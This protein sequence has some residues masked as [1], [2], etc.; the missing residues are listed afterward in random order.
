MEAVNYKLG[1]DKLW[2]G[3]TSITFLG[4]LLTGGKIFP[5]PEKT[6]AIDELLPP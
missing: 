2:L 4:F 5:D 3:Y 1:A 6:R